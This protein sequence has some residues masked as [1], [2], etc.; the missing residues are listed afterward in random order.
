[1]MNKLLKTYIF[2]LA[3]LGSNA[4]FAQ[5]Q[6]SPSVCHPNEAAH[7]AISQVCQSILSSNGNKIIN[8]IFHSGATVKLLAN[9][10]QNQGHF[11]MT[12][13][14]Q[15][16]STVAVGTKINV[17]Y[18]V[19]DQ[20]EVTVYIVDGSLNAGS[21]FHVEIGIDNGGGT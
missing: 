16:G 18:E 1:M 12:V 2:I 21:A 9:T 3:L 15:S 8:L 10:N 20:G 7:S 4:A 5:T 19:E 6:E 11:P 17:A 13:T 14:S